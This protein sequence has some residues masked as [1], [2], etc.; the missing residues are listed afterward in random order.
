MIVDFW[1]AVLI[2]TCQAV[3][4]GLFGTLLALL[5]CAMGK[6]DLRWGLLAGLV[7]TLGSWQVYRSRWMQMIEQILGVDSSIIPE[8]EPEAPRPVNVRVELVQDDGHRGDYIDLPA[9]PEQLQVLGSGLV[10][11]QPFS[12]AAW[13]G[14]NRP[15]TRNEFE[16][17]RVELF[18]RGLVRWS[19][20]HAKAQG[21]EL[22]PAGRAIFRRLATPPP[23]ELDQD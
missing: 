18:T 6:V 14:R 23:D 17:L 9:S 8:A 7:I 15:F 12:V 4:T 11:G 20:P 10:Q 19:S 1:R 22:T 3:I 16:T 2:P 13:T 5:F 21:V